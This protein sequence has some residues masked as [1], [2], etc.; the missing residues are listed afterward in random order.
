[1]VDADPLRQIEE[2]LTR[3]FRRGDV[4]GHLDDRSFVVALQGAP[5]RIATNRMTSLAPRLAA[6]DDMVRVGVAEFPGDGR[7]ADELSEAALAAVRRA[8]DQGGPRVVPTTWRPVDDRGVDVLIVDPDPVL[9]EMLSAALA[10]RGYRSDRLTD[11]HDALERL[12]EAGMES[13]PQVLL[14]D[15]DVG[16]IDGLTLLRSLR[17]AGVLSHMEVLVL[18]A[19]AAESDIRL[20]L[21]LG[22][23]DVVR[24]PMSTTLLLHR[25]SRLIER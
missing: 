18:S 13:L 14:L 8:A 4:V 1:M 25:V 24:K 12:T 16:G 3:E 15:T 6:S 9:G 23:A 10:E 19:R 20:A 21:D 17:P 11:G 2:T 5:R 22:A 7:S